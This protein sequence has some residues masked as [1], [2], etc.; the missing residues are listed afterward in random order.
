MM[1]MQRPML[2]NISI[3]STFQTFLRMNSNSKSA[4]LSFCYAI[5][6]HLPDCAMEHV[7]VSP[8]SVRGSLNAKYLEVNMLA[9]WLSSH[10]FLSRHLLLRIY[11]L[12]FDGPNFPYD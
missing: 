4:H 6:V 11:L 5:L 3:Q 2:L 12:S 10:G 8:A 7:F 9:I 1:G